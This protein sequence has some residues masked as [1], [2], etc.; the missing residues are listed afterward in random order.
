MTPLVEAEDSFLLCL[1]IVL[2]ILLPLC[3]LVPIVSNCL[4]QHLVFDLVGFFWTYS[5]CSVS[6]EVVVVEYF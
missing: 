1:F 5:V 3:I 4:P 6:F 2:S